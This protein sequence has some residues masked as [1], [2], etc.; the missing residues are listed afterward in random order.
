ME[1]ISNLIPKDALNSDTGLYFYTRRG[2]AQKCTMLAVWTVVRVRVM[3]VV[4]YKVNY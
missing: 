1:L 4:W 2:F 3:L